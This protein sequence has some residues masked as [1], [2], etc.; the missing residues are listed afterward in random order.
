MHEVIS[1]EI[2]NFLNFGDEKKQLVGLRQASGHRQ[3]L[4]SEA[5]SCLRDHI[6]PRNSAQGPCLL[7]F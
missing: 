1:I 6:V 5:A 2:L 3:K 4:A 7:M